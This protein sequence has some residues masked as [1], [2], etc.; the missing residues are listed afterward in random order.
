MY[1]I[2]ILCQDQNRKGATAQED[3]EAAKPQRKKEAQQKAAVAAQARADRCA[4][5]GIPLAWS[6]LVAATSGVHMLSLHKSDAAEWH[7]RAAW[8]ALLPELIII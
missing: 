4:S 7:E 2:C 5:I 1:G 3:L 8:T 6:M